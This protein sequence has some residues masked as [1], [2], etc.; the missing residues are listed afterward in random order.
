[1]NERAGCAHWGSMHSLILSPPTDTPPPRRGRHRAS[2]SVRRGNTVER[3]PQLPGPIAEDTEDQRTQYVSIEDD[4]VPHAA[5]QQ[6][7][8]ASA[9]QWRGVSALEPTPPLHTIGHGHGYTPFF[10]APLPAHPTSLHPSRLP[11][12]RLP[13]TPQR[14]KRLSPPHLRPPHP[15]PRPRV[16]SAFMTPSSCCLAQPVNGYAHAAAPK[17]FVY[18]VGPPLD[19]ALD[20]R[21]AGK[22][23]RWVRRT[24]CWPNGEV[25]AYVCPRGGMPRRHWER[26]ER[27]KRVGDE[28][29]PTKN[30]EE[31]AKMH[32]GIFATRASREGE[33]IMVAWGWDDANAVRRAGSLGGLA[34]H[35]LNSNSNSSSST[36]TP[37]R[38]RR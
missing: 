11:H 2:I 25:R 32:F 3:S 19:V 7:L 35:S 6:K 8:R 30:L 33:E 21:S 38:R 27:R 37:P 5:T 29:R 20:A 36:S 18:L 14:P 9:A 10:G 16:R 17:C 22:R 24:G 13:Q 12:P 1:M 34:A 15:R 31:D 28:S 26:E 4:L 23:G